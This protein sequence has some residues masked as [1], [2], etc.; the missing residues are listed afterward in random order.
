MS[1]R[2]KS[3]WITLITLIVLALFY[4]THLPPAWMLDP[5]PSGWM[6]HVLAVGVIAFVVIEI[7][8]HVIVAIRAPRD[9]QAPRDER[10]RLIALKAT[11]IAAYVYAVLSL[12][13]VFTVIHLGANEI[14]VFYCVFLSFIL[15][16]IVNYAA[17]IV[18]YRRGV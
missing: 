14:G 12:G 8:A 5:P 1:F 6:F 13:S 7:V 17:R 11:S 4:I 16:E 3:A 10:E 9:A 15:A 2:E 18:Y